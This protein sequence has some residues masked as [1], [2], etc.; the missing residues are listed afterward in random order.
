MAAPKCPKMFLISRTYEY[1]T[2]WLWHL[3][4]CSLALCIFPLLHQSLLH[5]HDYPVLLIIRLN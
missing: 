4:G 3:D 5:S 1:V 2:Q